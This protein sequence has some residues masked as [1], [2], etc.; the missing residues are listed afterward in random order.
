MTIRDGITVTGTCELDI[1]D[2][3]HI[4]HHL[5][6]LISYTTSDELDASPKFDKYQ[7]LIIGTTALQ[8]VM[9]AVGDNYAWYVH[10]PRNETRM[11]ARGIQLGNQGGKG[12]DHASGSIIAS[13][14][15]EDPLCIVGIGEIGHH[16]ITCWSEAGY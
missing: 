7:L 3:K 8:A 2:A 4:G 14:N 10:D 16:K 12:Y 13:E 6:N 11:S 9:V 15:A 5:R 1:L